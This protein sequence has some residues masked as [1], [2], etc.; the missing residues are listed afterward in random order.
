M[1]CGGRLSELIEV[2]I[3]AFH[4]KSPCSL[5]LSQ[6]AENEMTSICCIDWRAHWE[7]VFCTSACGFLL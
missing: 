4:I 7:Q 6:D 2:A 3:W 1:L 5:L